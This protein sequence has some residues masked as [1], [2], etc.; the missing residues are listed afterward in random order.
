MNDKRLTVIITGYNTLRSDWD[1]SISSA[2]ASLSPDDEIV[3]VDDGSRDK[4]TFLFGYQQNDAR[5]RILLLAENHGLSYARNQGMATSR[6]MYIAFVDADDE[7]LPGIYGRAIEQ[8]AQRGEDMVI[9]GVKVVWTTERLQREC[10]CQSRDLGRVGAVDVKDLYERRLLNYAWNKV[11]RKAFILE[12]GLSFDLQGV[13]C[14]DIIFN[15]QLLLAGARVGTVSGIGYVY[16]RVQGTL[17]SRYKSTYRAG[18]TRCNELWRKYKST[19]DE[20]GKNLLKGVGEVSSEEMAVKEWENMW[21]QDSPCSLSE[22]WRYLRCHP[23]VRR[24]C[25]K[26]L[27]VCRTAIYRLLRA[28]CYIRL[29]RR[30]HIRRIYPE[31]VDL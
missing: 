20:A 25:P 12:R 28:T 3:C 24:G 30:W 21:L 15:L 16:Y 26:F 17:L 18:T 5:V 4:P 10:V 6:G 13:P 14:E 8:L 31:V 22:R 27:F 2:L 11:Y 1:R 29:I 7:V 9:F 23:E 19:L